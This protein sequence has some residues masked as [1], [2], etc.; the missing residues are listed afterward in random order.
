[1]PHQRCG[2]D[3]P[4]A[5]MSF[6]QRSS[7]SLRPPSG[8][9]WPVST[10][11]SAKDS[12]CS[13][14]LTTAGATHAR[15]CLSPYNRTVDRECG[16]LI[17]GSWRR[18]QRSILR[19]STAGPSDLLSKLI[20][21]VQNVGVEERVLPTQHLLQVGRVERL[22]HAARTHPGRHSGQVGRAASL[23]GS[24]CIPTVK[25]KIAARMRCRWPHVVPAVRSPLPPRL[26]THSP[27]PPTP[28]PRPACAQ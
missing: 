1:M 21:M 11:A 8:A 23:A 24:T 26:P 16:K 6:F 19:M 4:S 15:Y 28:S 18:S 25:K 17:E 7:R 10:Q 13:G 12:T 3:I 20:V 14:Q 9:S 27:P 22:T 5:L 2:P